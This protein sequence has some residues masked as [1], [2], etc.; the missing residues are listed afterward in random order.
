MMTREELAAV[1]AHEL[2]HIKSRDTLTMTVAATIG[3]AISMVAQWLQVSMLFGSNRNQGRSRFA[4]FAAMLLAPVRRHAGADG[5]QP[6][7]RVSGRPAR[8]DDLRQSAVARERA[9]QDPRR[10]AP[11]IPNP[12]AQQVPA[13]AHLFIIS[14]LTGRGMDSWFTTHP[15]TENRIAELEKLAAEMGQ[16]ANSAPGRSSGS[17]LP[18]PG[19]RG[20]L[21]S[22]ARPRGPWSSA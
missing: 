1:M 21:S 14:P 19:E 12:A 17:F 16:V 20:I 6:V 8:R 18:K 10:R 7:A 9:G 3:G 13:M 4:T 2:A 5:D 11:Q 15:S 22:D